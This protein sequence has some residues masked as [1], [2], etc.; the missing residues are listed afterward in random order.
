MTDTASLQ[1]E[2]TA[3]DLSLKPG[4]KPANFGEFVKNYSTLEEAE[5]AWRAAEE[6]ENDVVWYDDVPNAL[7][8]ATAVMH[9]DVW[10]D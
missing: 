3:K 8:M 4:Y 5:E 6:T 7:Y 9:D 10:K 1:V 2:F